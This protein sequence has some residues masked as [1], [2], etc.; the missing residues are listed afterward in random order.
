MQKLSIKHT[1]AA[2][3]AAALLAACG[4]GG[5]TPGADV[6][7]VISGDTGTCTAAPCYNFSESNLGLVDFGGLGIEVAN[8]PKLATNKVVK[9]TKE[10][11]DEAWA[12]VTVHFGGASNSVPR[13]DASKT[14]SL[15]VYS[16]AV[17][18][19]IMIKIENAA[20]G[21][22]FK[23]ASAKS[24]KASEWETLTFTFA[25]DAAAT[26]NKI[27]VFPG[28]DTKVAE[29]YYI[30]ELKY[31]TKADDVVVVPPTPAAGLTLVNFDESTPAVL[32]AFEGTSFVAATDGANKVAQLNKPMTAQAWGGATFKSC[33]A[34]TVGMTPAIPFTASNQTISVRVKAPRAGVAFS[35]EAK[36]ASN[37]TNLVFAEATSTTTEWETLTFNFAN[38]TFGTAINPSQTYNA[39]SIFPNFSKANEVTAAKETADRV[40]LIDDVKLVGS[41]AT[42]GTC[43]A[44]PVTGAP[45]TAPATPSAA[46]PDVISIYSDAYTQTAGVNLNPNWGQST[47]V[48]EET[49]ANN[50]VQKYTSF[51]YQ[52]IDFSNNPINV[53]SAAGFTQLH[54]DFWSADATA[55]KVFLISA[56]P[57]EQAVDVPLTASA[58]KSI[59]IP[60]SSFTTPNRAA[61]IQLKLVAEPSGKTVFFDNI[62]F[63]K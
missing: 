20:N 60:L 5:S 38:K 18:K 30:D 39:L 8:D 16:P 42:L 28:F 17:G 25:D 10:A 13:I 21:G 26:F 55:V 33:P 15:R 54:V 4:G 53:S 47:A 59:D 63:K 45:T 29:V 12:G 7:G 22:V 52:G 9:L 44:V 27:S 32:D 19:T 61:I 46:V 41:S 11:T 51:N 57:V 49:I 6:P 3:A 31:S 58:W 56:G 48:T 36:D 37:H 43:P 34:G 23:E 62:Y 50:K 2:L 14:I 24:T 1:A 35:L 40:Y